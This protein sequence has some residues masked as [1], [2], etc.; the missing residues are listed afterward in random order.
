MAEPNLQPP[1]DRATEQWI[2][3]TREFL[4]ECENDQ[5]GAKEI[6]S[7]LQYNYT[8]EEAAREIKEVVEYASS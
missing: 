8:P 3:A 4:T 5:L 2:E 6:Q 7:F 1:E